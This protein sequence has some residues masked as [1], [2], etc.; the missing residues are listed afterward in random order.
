MS[1]INNDID[2]LNRTDSDQPEI[3]AMQNN[4]DRTIVIDRTLVADR[5]VLAN[6]NASIQNADNVDNGD[7][8]L[9]PEVAAT[10][11][12]QGRPTQGECFILKGTQYNLVRSLSENSGEAQIFLVSNNGKEY[13]LKVYY[14]NYD[15][16]KKL[17]QAIHSFHFE[18]LVRLDDFGKTYVDGKHRCY[19]LMEY[20]QGGTLQEYN[21]NGDYNQF[22]RITLQAGAALSYCHHYNILHKDIKPSNFFFRDKTHTQL[23]LGDF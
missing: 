23:A 7:R 4:G 10:Q 16:N 2:R 19:E 3:N 11:E 22:R 21:L 1:D 20:M 15:F 5:T 12:P 13:V 9:R 6:N 18:M 8:T 14:P 17:M